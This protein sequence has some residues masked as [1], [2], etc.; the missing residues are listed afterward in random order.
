MSPGWALLLVAV[1]I[2]ANGL[3]VA[4]EFGLVAARQGPLEEAAASG[5]RRAIA[6]V[7]QLGRLSFVLS[8]AQFGITATS[9]VVGF[10]AEDALGSV[11]TPILR[12]T[13]LRDEARTTVAVALA[14]LLSTVFQ[15]LLGELAPKNL[16]L[17]LPER[18]AIA[19]ALPMRWFGLLLGPII[20]LFDASAA[21]LTRRV[22]GVEVAHERLGGHSADELARIIAAS[23]D[24]G[25]LS[26]SQGQLLARAVALG[27]RRVHEI[28]VP[29][30]SVV[31]LSIHDTLE[32][33]RVAARRT[34]HSRFPLRAPDDDDVVGTVHI[35]DVLA[36]A[37]A[38]RATTT[39][40][41]IM[42][43]P[44]VVPES[45]P[46]RRVLGQLRARSRTFALVI[47]EYG[48]VAGIVTIEDV[49]EELVGEIED[50]FDSEHGAIQDKG[51]GRWLLDGTVRV[52]IAGETLGWALP[53]G[54]YETVAGLLIDQ[55]GRIP[56][57]GAATVVDG[58]E[59]VAHR[60]D[61]V[62][63]AQVMVCELASVQLDTDADA[64]AS[65]DTAPA[66]TTRERK[67]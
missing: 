22:F 67:L 47:D 18:T 34:G 25:E 1:L 11:V 10:L 23:R 24:G 46:L 28:M 39:L 14:F 41:A 55:L 63:V 64:S 17:A 16:A 32:D 31:F 3:F 65:A 58:W 51:D 44:V 4:F 2:V 49:L 50:E 13:G 8:S 59:I 19:L 53:T 52:D 48:A 12:A 37:Q 15:M 7:K 29:R 21:V 54:D 6:A 42:S 20:R 33:L 61:G 66:D 38:D 27:D 30:T 40:G 35:K 45:E 56:R 62:R 5:D 36:V 26:D 9:L 57:T 43:P 60:V